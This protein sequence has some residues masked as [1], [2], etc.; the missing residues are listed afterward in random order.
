MGAKI[1]EVLQRIFLIEDKIEAL[2]DNFIDYLE[3]ESYYIKLS[4]DVIEYEDYIL[5]KIDIPGIDLENLKIYHKDN[6]LI[7]KGIKKK[8]YNEEKVNFIVAE[9]RFGHFYNIFP[10]PYEFDINSI[11]IKIENGV[12]DIKI[13]KKVDKV[14]V[15]KKIDIE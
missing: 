5:I 12:L 14:T 2:A 8:E 4:S 15:I 3:N 7:V 11:D 10:I 9:R 6:N 1:N 13:P